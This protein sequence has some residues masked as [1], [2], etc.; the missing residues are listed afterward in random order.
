M[1]GCGKKHTKFVHID[2]PVEG[3]QNCTESATQTTSLMIRSGTVGASASACNVYLPIVPVIVN[4]SYKT[5][6]LL[7]TGSTN[8]FI[9]E[10]LAAHLHL[11]GSDVSYVINTLSSSKNVDCKAVSFSL[12]NG[13]DDESY[14][15]SNVMVIPNIPARYPECA[16][17]VKKYP[18]LANLP[19]CMPSS[20]TRV[21]ILL[22]MDNSRLLMPLEVRAD[23]RG[24]G[25]PYATRTRLGWSLNGLID[26]HTH[27]GDVFSNFVDLEQ[28]VENMW[29]IEH[30]DTRDLPLSHNDQKVSELWDRE[31]SH[32]DG[33]Y[34]LPI[35][36]KDGRPSL[37]DN[38]YVAKCR[39]DSLLRRL[40][41]I[42]M[43]SA[44][45]ENIRKM[46]TEGY[47][48]LVPENELSRS[49]GSVWYLPHHHVVNAAKP[50]KIRIV[51]DCAAK[52]SGVSLNNQRFRGPDLTN[53]L[54][55]VLLRFR[56]YKYCVIADVEAM[57]LQVKIPEYD[58]N[59]LRFLWFHEGKVVSYRM[60]SHLFGGIW[61]ASSSTFALRHT[62]CDFPASD[63]VTDT[64]LRSFYVD[65]MLRS[66]KTLDEVATVVHGVNEVLRKG[67]FNLTKFILNETEYLQKIPVTERAKEVKDITSEMSSKALG[68]RWE[69]T[70]D[71][72][73]YVS[74]NM[75]DKSTITRRIML[76]QVSG[77]YDP[78]VLI[79][80][81]VLEG[82]MLFQ[83]ATRLKLN[84]DMPVPKGL[85]NKWLCWL[86]SLSE[87]K[88]L[89]FERCVI[90]EKFTE[91]AAELHT[92]CDASEKGYGACTYIRIINATGLIHVALLVGKGRVAPL[93]QITIPRLE[94]CAAVV[95]V[96]LDRLVRQELDVELLQST[97][98]M[99]SKVVLAYIHNDTKCFKTFV[100][101]RVS[102]IR[103]VSEKS[104]WHHIPGRDNPADVV[105]H[106][107]HAKNLPLNWIHGPEFLSKYKCNW[108]DDD[109][110]QPISTDDPEVRNDSAQCVTNVASHAP[111][112]HP[113]DKLILHYSCFYRLKKALCW[114]IHFRDYL[115]GKSTISKSHIS[116]P[117]LRDA[118]RVIIQHV[119]AWVYHETL[120]DL[121]EK[122]HVKKSDRLAAL[123]PVLH[124]GVIIVGGRLRHA[125][126]A[127]LSK[128]P[129]II[130]H[131]HKVAMLIM[132]EIHNGAHLGTAWVPSKLRQKYWIVNA[133]N[134]IKCVKRQ[135]VT[136]KRLYAT[137][138]TQKM[139]DLPQ[140]RCQS[141]KPPFTY[142]GV[143]LCGPFHVKRGRSTVKRYGCL[144]TC[145]TTRAI[146]VEKLD[147]LETD[148][149]I[150]G[151]V[152]FSSRKGY[153]EKVWS[154]NG[155]NIVG[156]EK[157]IRK[158]L[159][160][161]D[162]AK[163]VQ[164]AR[165]HRVEWIFNPPHASHQGGIW[166]RMI[167]TLRKVMVALL[168][169]SNVAMNDEVLNT[170]F[171]E[172]EGIVNSRPITKCSDD[173]N[174]EQALTPNHFL[175]M[176]GN[177]P[178]PWGGF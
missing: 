31:I 105:S 30:C 79:S 81:I 7:D 93:K 141:G 38:K 73:Y 164:A 78:L 137:P 18:H 129:P 68:I 60:T 149:F 70:S 33:H 4:G 39:L 74:E 116:F 145:F 100:S 176:K 106:G 123:S 72:F 134:L 133:R 8:S 115:R 14:R 101:N 27:S 142:V 12:S 132:R 94:L 76:S 75:S 159:S 169:A 108:T 49:D 21:D 6:A 140:E 9:T 160:Q 5:Y 58:R 90:P 69:V 15:V 67:G 125:C 113:I 47:A 147:S 55:N 99:D 89:R 110:E 171:C 43:M 50:G 65:D 157:E 166:E 124:Q 167:R 80:P 25:Q 165:R 84:W 163:I 139:A 175:L 59:A 10:S 22:G 3:V 29:N 136:C 85:S 122:G 126:I 173:A 117:E 95:A 57:Y 109:R 131:D 28:K 92:F 112:P 162:R 103:E 32:A 87:L 170:L 102:N 52:Y 37:P 88:S 17:D 168:N 119:Q 104:Q 34:T 153:P 41:K 16:I 177:L 36:W 130:P 63:L 64:V 26:G 48:E 83:E 146:H 158:S 20:D 61:C 53:K 19:L 128:S 44:Y 161:L 91:G 121:G 144:Y 40:E 120:K 138:M 45:D 118:E 24:P 13:V 62:V 135:C 152:R 97:F 56:Q 35:P 107:C 82:R 46:I 172:I 154:D 1:P 66:I 23:E 174:D 86:N 42:N 2:D 178:L 11:V 98:W 148:S 143:D 51:F 150:N 71:C 155:T 127:E 114:L 77:M 151:F 96:K 156:A 111:N 54:I